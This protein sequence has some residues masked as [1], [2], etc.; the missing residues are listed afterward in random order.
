VRLDPLTRFPV[1]LPVMHEG[2][3]VRV[4]LQGG[5]EAAVASITVF[6]D[7]EDIEMGSSV[8]VV[9]PLPEVAPSL[10]L[11]V[12][13]EEAAAAVL[14]SKDEEA[15]PQDGAVGGGD[16]DM[17]DADESAKA[18]AVVDKSG[19][20][21][22]EKS[23]V[24][25]GENGTKAS[26]VVEA[27]AEVEQVT[28]PSVKEEDKAKDNQEEDGTAMDDAAPD[29]NASVEE[30]PAKDYNSTLVEITRVKK[31]GRPRRH[32]EFIVYDQQ[33]IRLRYLIEVVAVGGGG[34]GNDKMEEG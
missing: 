22:T 3:K 30:P 19:M 9:V 2:K 27:E 13:K 11:L 25:E 33:Q 14:A 32:S 6:G 1:A 34:G 15:K 20:E 10:P 7:G 8:R 23:K 12:S 31:E 18:D 29:V 5:P 28:T 24:E 4:F 21:G 26:E 16:E 17:L